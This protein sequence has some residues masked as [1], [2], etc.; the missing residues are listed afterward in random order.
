MRLNISLT[1]EK[2]L[3]LPLSHNHMI[4]AFI[5]SQLE[6]NLANWLHGEAYSHA[7]RSYKMFTFSRLNGKY[8]I[9]AKKETISFTGPV[10][11]QLASC[12][13]QILSSLA[14]HLLKSQ[15][16]RLGYNTLS[17]SGI[18]ILKAPQ[19]KP[20][21]KLRTLSP[22]TMYSTFTKPDGSKLTHYYAP[23]EK[24]WNKLILGNLAKKAKALEWE[25]NA[26][27]ALSNSTIKPL[28]Q[29]PKDKKVVKYKNFFIEAYQGVFEASLPEAYFE[30]AYDVGLGGKNAQGFGMMEVI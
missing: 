14:E 8:I 23:Y 2:P 21:L 12:N 26:D 3:N 22:I 1:T 30:L 4:Q 11:F 6:P 24:D 17:V 15:T 20:K 5:Y 18:E 16:S 25:S 7:K 27:E 28:R 19:Y 10:S 9:E 13:H 29:N